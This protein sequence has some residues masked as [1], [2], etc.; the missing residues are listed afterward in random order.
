MTDR[1]S[2]RSREQQAQAD[3]SHAI[4]QFRPYLTGL[5]EGPPAL[6]AMA[7]AVLRF[8]TCEL[9]TRRADRL[10]ALG[11]AEAEA[12]ALVESALASHERGL[13]ALPAVRPYADALAAQ[14]PDDQALSRWRVSS[15]A[16]REEWR[17]Q[18]A[19]LDVT[20]NDARH[21]VRIMDECC[22][23]IDENGL[24]GLGRYL[25][26]RLDDLDQARR[27]EDRGTHAASFPWWKIVAAAAILGMTAYAVW[28]LVS[29][30][31]PWW[32]FYLVALVACIMMLFVAM[33]C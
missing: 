11:L 27:S 22:D 30:G 8:G 7:E 4:L 3:F 26:A 32:N 2:W 9:R 6:D 1:P 24:G 15:P 13:V 31:A 17:A 28:V 33:G 18:V 12:A 10:R 21:M 19:E 23:T 25:S 14:P 20:P 29:S 5:P 16:I